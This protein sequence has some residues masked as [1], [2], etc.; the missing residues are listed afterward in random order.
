MNIDIKIDPNAIA[1]SIEA[2]FKKEDKAKAKTERRSSPRAPKR[3][4]REEGYLPTG[5]IINSAYVAAGCAKCPLKIFSDNNKCDSRLDGVGNKLSK[6][7]VVFG[8]PSMQ[9]YKTGNML[10][11][12]KVV[13]FINQVNQVAAQFGQAEPIGIEDGKIISDL[14]YLT[15]Y[16]K[17][18]TGDGGMSS[19]VANCCRCAL[20]DEFVNMNIKTMLLIGGEFIKAAYGDG[21]LRINDHSCSIQNGVAIFSTYNPLVMKRPNDFQISFGNKLVHWWVCINNNDFVN[22][23]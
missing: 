23:L 12:T 9:A 13:E 16:V 4:P 11:D 2:K 17:C 1:K 18:T 3:K 8:D 21:L 22:K 7:V 5:K 6:H 20:E 10:K 14:L 15:Y 19:R